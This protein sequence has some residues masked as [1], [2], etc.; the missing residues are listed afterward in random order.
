MLSVAAFHVSRGATPLPA[1][2]EVRARRGP[3]HAPRLDPLM[4]PRRA[5]AH[6]PAASQEGSGSRLASQP[7]GI[8]PIPVY[9]ATTPP[10][11]AAVVSTSPPATT[12][13]ATA[14]G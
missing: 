12:H 1:R 11:I 10:A 13:A 5:P 8:P 3:A 2:V 9:A 4:H 14:A 7:P 6:S